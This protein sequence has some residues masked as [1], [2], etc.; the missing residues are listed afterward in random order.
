MTVK[1]VIQCAA[2]KQPGGFW[3]GADGRLVKFVAHPERAPDSELRGILLAHPDASESAGG[4]SWR[5]SIVKYNQGSENPLGLFQAFRLYEQPVYGQLVEKF[6]AANVFILSAGWGL[7][8]S[9]FRTPNY[10][11]TFSASADD[12]KRRL[13]RDR[14][15]DIC[16]LSADSSPIVFLGGKDY[17]GLFLELTAQSNGPRIIYFNSAQVPRPRDCIFLRY[18]TTQRTNWHYACASDLIAGRLKIPV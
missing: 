10:D 1:I 17:T 5:E 13:A 7:I 15:R 11:I 18:E 16:G 3:R 4:P 9:T 6:G 12:F 14:Y 2:G 8:P